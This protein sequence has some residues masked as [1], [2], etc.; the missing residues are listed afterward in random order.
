MIRTCISS[1]HPSSLPPSLLLPTL[2]LPLSLFKLHQR[3]PSLA[4]IL[5]RISTTTHPTTANSTKTKRRLTPLPCTT[6]LTTP[7]CGLRITVSIF[8]LSITT[9]GWSFF[10]LCPSST[11]T[12]STLHGMG[13]ST[14]LATSLTPRALAA[15]AG[16]ARDSRYC[17]PRWKS[18]RRSASR[19]KVV[20]RRV[21]G[22]KVVRV[23]VEG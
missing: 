11:S 7:S 23:F 4:K 14:L 19:M 15:H 21:C 12:R 18:V 20:A 2:P 3:R 16:S 5:R 8:M 17:A 10:T 13:A 9:S 22:K 6:L 1:S